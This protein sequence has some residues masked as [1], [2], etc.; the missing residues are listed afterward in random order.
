MS[1][2]M[3]AAKIRR[4]AQIAL[5]I[6]AILAAV[7]AGVRYLLRGGSPFG[8]RVIATP[9]EGS[10][11][12]RPFF[13][14]QGYGDGQEINVY[15][16]VSATGGVED[17]ANLG[18]G[19]GGQRLRA[20]PIPK[21][22]PDTTEVV[23]GKYVI[24]VGPDASGD[25]PERGTFEVVAFNA[26]KKPKPASYAGVAPTSLKIGE[27]EIVARGASCGTPTFL[28][29]GRLAIGATVVDP[30][31]GVTVNIDVS[32]PG[33][34]VWSPVG[35]KLAILTNDR[36]EIRLAAPDGSGATTRV[37]EARG[38]IS[39]LT[40]S[41]SGDQLA[42]IAQNDPTTH[43]GPGPPSVWIL[44]ATTGEKRL[45]GPGLSVAWSPRPDVLAVQMS[46]GQ[47]LSMTPSNGRRALGT[48]GSPAWS[49]DGSYL[50]SIRGGQGF[51]APGSGG[52]GGLAVGSTG[53][54]AMAFSPNG[55]AIAVVTR[56][57]NDVTMRLRPVTG[58]VRTGQ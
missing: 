18:K 16:C 8:P 48:G 47:I 12:M 57:G 53:V 27:G 51:I 37:R 42:Y 49:P 6:V 19:R 4:Y 30:E 38:L 28:P 58:A 10:V 45:V 43:G 46:G 3:D 25:Y 33:N 5:A 40:W 32:D 41:P 9:L 55:R 31:S 44:N 23:P 21:E 1:G 2:P 35:D 34:L 26:G 20:N 29:D 36:K 15:L 50:T 52:G 14:F 22:L 39:S 56:A 54:C 7:A 11:G 17:C 24:R 13:D